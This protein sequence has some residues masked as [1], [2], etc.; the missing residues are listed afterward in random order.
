MLLT[1]FLLIFFLYDGHRL[2]GYVTRLVPQGSRERVRG[3]SAAGF[4]TLETYVR[5]TVL[6][7]AIDAAVIGIGLAILG[8]PL[9]LPLVLII[10]L[11]SFIPIVGSFVSGSLAVAVTLTT[12][13]WVNAVIV[14]A[15]LVFVMTFE[16]HVLQPFVLG[17]SVKLH[18]A[19]VILA[20]AFGL[21]LAGLVGGLLAVP[22]VAFLDT[23]F[24]WH[25]RKTVPPP[26]DSRFTE[27]LRGWLGLHHRPHASSPQ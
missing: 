6:V 2:W 8:V 4:R 15:I 26:R 27:W 1:V 14:L 22:L 11:G 23:A 17:R 19:A 10:F 25:P 16:G 5:A 12:Q 13:G 7:A 24:T 9:V 3:A 20:I 21:M 18:P